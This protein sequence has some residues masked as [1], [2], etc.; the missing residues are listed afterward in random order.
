MCVYSLFSP[1]P[2][3]PTMPSF[4]PALMTKLSPLRTMGVFSLYFI[5]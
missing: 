1:D 2:V 5:L 3:L 4:S